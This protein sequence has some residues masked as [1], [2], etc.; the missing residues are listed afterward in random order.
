[1]GLLV[2]AALF[3]ALFIAVGLTQGIGHPEVPSGDVALIEDVPGDSGHI[4]EA[5]FHR[6][7]LRASLLAG[8]AKPPPQ[9]TEQFEELTKSALG[10]LLHEVWLK[11]EAAEL[12]ISVSPQEAI[13]SLK[14]MKKQTFSSEA[15]Y[16][17]FLKSSHYTP[18]DARR[19]AGLQLLS[20]RLE[21]YVSANAPAPSESQISA[22]YETAKAVQFTVPA[23]GSKPAKVE[24]L[25]QVKPHIEAQ[26]AKQDAEEAFE[27]FAEDYEAKWAQR[28][29]CSA[30]YVIEGCS[31]FRG[32]GHPANA[33]AA[34][35]EA[36]PR[37]GISAPACPAPVTPLAPALPGTVSVLL[38]KG[39]QLPQ[40]PRPQGQASSSQ[41]PIPKEKP[42]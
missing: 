10:P 14:E 25:A 38:P 39:T 4:S 28:T 35:Y 22:Y 5:E 16:R 40:R 30:G 9:G 32:S 20:T 31:S 42:R 13:A 1:M 27:A 29:F 19:L 24:S 15:E 26:L 2:F 17:R 7:L 37:A 41:Q 8:E 12:G 36:H 34:C 23:K 3:G 33:P 11:G 21:E 18:A 6:A